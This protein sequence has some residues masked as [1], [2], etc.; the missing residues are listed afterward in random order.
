M[1]VV[2]SA[3]CPDNPCVRVSTPHSLVAAGLLVLLALLAC[4]T[5]APS[6]LQ[7]RS[8]RQLGCTPAYKLKVS[9]QTLGDPRQN[10]PER[11]SVT[12]CGVAYRCSS[13]LMATG[14]PAHTECVEARSAAARRVGL[15]EAQRRQI[16][17]RLKRAAIQ[18]AA[19][20]SGCA[21]ARVRIKGELVQGTAYIHMVQACGRSFRCLTL[22]A[23]SLRE[24]ATE[25]DA[26]AED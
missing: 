17:A 22:G 10:K 3:R 15:T 26:L 5:P 18:Q 25:C 23:G 19:D 16:S 13:F 20:T 24:S 8:A 2:R 12:G 7:T 11:W 21:P 14:E 9:G 4:C 1:W 6:V